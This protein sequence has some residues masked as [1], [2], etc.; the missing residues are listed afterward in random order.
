M[1][2]LDR[3]DEDEAERAARSATTA[4]VRF[5]WLVKTGCALPAGLRA[6]WTALKSG[7]PKWRDKWVDDAVATDD[8]R[9]GWVGTNED[10][11]VLDGL[12]IGRIVQVAR[13]HGGI[14][15]DPFVENEPFTGLVKNRPRRAIAALG[16]ASRRRDFPEMLWESAMRDWPDHAPRRATKVLHGHLCRLPCTTILAMRHTVGAWLSDRFPNVAA[17]DRARAHDVFDHVVGCLLAAGSA[18]AE[19]GLGEQTIGGEPV[20]GSRQTRAHAM[21]GPIGK[22][23]EGLLKVLANESPA[24]GA[25]LPADFKARVDRPWPLLAREGVMPSV[26]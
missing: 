8:V 13:E 19:S 4:A 24:Q 23:V 7:L 14:F 17:D 3:H 15:R 22:A 5:G 25:A 6:K 10:A 2:R 16:A 18:A 26:S 9:G 21:N 20:Q 12:S 11:S 1:V